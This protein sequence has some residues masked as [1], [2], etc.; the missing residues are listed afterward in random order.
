M[1]VIDNAGFGI[2][3]N[4]ALGGGTPDMLVKPRSEP[5]RFA[6]CFKL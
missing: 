4:K 6:L 3:P 5:N 1:T 2:Q